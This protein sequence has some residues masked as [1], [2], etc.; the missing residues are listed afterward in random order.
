MPSCADCRRASDGTEAILMRFRAGA[1]AASAI[2]F[3]VWAVQASPVRAQAEERCYGVAR[4][5]DNDGIGRDSN[6]GTSTVDYQGD[7]WV[8]VPAG[9]CLTMPLP[10]QPDGTPRRGSLQPLDRDRP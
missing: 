8:A 2:A 7:A 6:P 9:R 5:G 10:V 3:A 4:A 1:A